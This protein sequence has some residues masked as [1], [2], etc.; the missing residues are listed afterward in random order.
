MFI[1]CFFVIEH[2]YTSALQHY[3]IPNVLTPKKEKA[4]CSSISD[5]N[6]KQHKRQTNMKSSSEFR[7]ELNS[8]VSGQCFDYNLMGKWNKVLNIF[9]KALINSFD[10]YICTQIAWWQQAYQMH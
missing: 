6:M 1:F 9:I 10:I 4:K 8:P 5:E 3:S 7:P 2:N